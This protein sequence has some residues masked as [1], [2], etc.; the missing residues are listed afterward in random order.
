MGLGFIVK[1]SSPRG[2]LQK[3]QQTGLFKTNEETTHGAKSQKPGPQIPSSST[4]VDEH[5]TKDLIE[6]TLE[7]DPTAFEY[8]DIYDSMNADQ[9]AKYAKF[10]TDRRLQ[11][12]AH[13]TSNSSPA[14][15]DKK[16]NF[17][18]ASSSNPAKSSKYIEIMKINAEKRKIELEEFKL[19]RMR[20]EN[21]ISPTGEEEPTVFVTSSYRKKLEDLR[22]KGV[23]TEIGRVPEPEE[24]EGAEPK[25][26]PDNPFQ[27][28]MG[29]LA[30]SHRSRSR[31]PNRQ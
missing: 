12:L 19:R 17:E 1:N 16:T 21:A 10:A 6:K 14:L 23:N 15:N 30:K 28:R 29:L 24:C 27:M 7:E 22:A 11:A 5:K 13:L 9:R 8:D 4:M 31:S 25:G 26:E 18:D 20:K 3:P 2:L